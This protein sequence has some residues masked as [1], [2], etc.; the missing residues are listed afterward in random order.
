MRRCCA[1]EIWFVAVVVVGATAA[2]LG[3]DGSGGSGSGDSDTLAWSNITV[4]VESV[5]SSFVCLCLFA[6]Y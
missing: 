4:R 6:S 3:N 1:I 5:C 2:V